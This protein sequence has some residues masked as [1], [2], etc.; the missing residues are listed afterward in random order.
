[1]GISTVSGKTALQGYELDKF[2][3]APVIRV[4]TRSGY[5]GHILIRLGQAS[6]AQFIEYPSLTWILHC[7]M[8]INNSAWS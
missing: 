4:K 3:S 1:M 8:C 6:L 5:P 2:I 7:I